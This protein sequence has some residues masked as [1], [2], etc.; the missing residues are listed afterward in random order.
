MELIRVDSI[1][2]HPAELEHEEDGV[3][4]EPPFYGALDG[5][6]EPYSYLHPPRPF[7]DFTGGE[8]IVKT[9]KRNFL[10]A[11]PALP[12]EA[13]LQLANAGI[14]KMLAA[15]ELPVGN[16]GLMPGAVFAVAKVEVKTIKFIQ[17]GDCLIVWHFADGKIDFTRNQAYGHVSHNLRTIEEILAK[18]SGN[19]KEMW[20]EFAP[21]LSR[22]REQDINNPLSA[23]NYAVLNSQPDIMK[24]WIAGEIPLRN[25][26][27]LLVFTDGF[28]HYEQTSPDKIAFLAAKLIDDYHRKRLASGQ[29]ET[30]NQML[31]EKRAEAKT[32]IK[33]SYIDRDEAAA[34]ALEF[35]DKEQK[36]K[37]SYFSRQE[38]KSLCPA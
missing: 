13:Y 36:V 28:A 34:V 5:F 10:G 38:L 15:E 4:M 17:G 6:S 9:V 3:I 27:T 2:D 1:C 18:N 23:N 19:R 31:A 8:M 16:A 25:L 32:C 11:N 12:I 35:G 14:K 20:V 30:L 21:I 37:V 24:C 22:R 29:K 7:N 26:T 33:L